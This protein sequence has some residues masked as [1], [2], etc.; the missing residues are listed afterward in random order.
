MRESQRDEFIAHL[1]AFVEIW[2][3]QLISQRGHRGVLDISINTMI[4][5]IYQI[6]DVT[7]HSKNKL[8]WR[9]EIFPY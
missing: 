5:M 6:S 8:L 3:P 2:H 1:Q 9:S 4:Y 7:P